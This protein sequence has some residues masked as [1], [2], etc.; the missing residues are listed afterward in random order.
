MIPQ[1]LPDFALLNYL[2]KPGKIPNSVDGI[3]VV[4]KPQGW[5]SFDVVKKIGIIL[6]VKVGHTG[7]LDPM[8]T[9]VLVLLIGRA[10]KSAQ[11]FDND[12][13]RYQAE[14]TFGCSTTTYDSEG[15]TTGVGDPAK[16]QKVVL[17]NAIKSFEG[18]SEQYPPMFSAVKHKGKRLYQ[19]ARAGQTVERKS[20]NIFIS[21]IELKINDYPRITLDIECSKGTYIRVIAHQ[22]GQMVGCPAHLSALT[23]TKCGNFDIEDSIDILS[24]LHNNKLKS[25]H[26]YIKSLEDFRKS[27]I[28]ESI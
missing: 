10:T 15:E 16:V 23:R 12:R 4:N 25:I 20:R 24:L 3:L 6:G 26:N 28:H 2:K 13:K 11:L 5:T 1:W 14:I 21:K 18:N 22:L 27:T 9:G 7:T 19:L 17:L 8:A